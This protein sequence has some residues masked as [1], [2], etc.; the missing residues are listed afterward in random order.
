MNTTTLGIR[1]TLPGDETRVETID[2]TVARMNRIIDLIRSGADAEPV[3]IEVKVDKHLADHYRRQ[4]ARDDVLHIAQ[5][6]FEQG[7]EA[8]AAKAVA[9]LAAYSDLPDALR[10]ERLAELVGELE[11]QARIENRDYDAG[12]CGPGEDHQALLEDAD[13]R[14]FEAANALIGGAR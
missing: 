7:D 5:L 2:N 14:V 10:A 6:V 1:Y 4:A 9:D 11:H 3:T 12:L 13:Q 8:T